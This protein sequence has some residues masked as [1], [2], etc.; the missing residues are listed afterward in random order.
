MIL[1]DRSGRIRMFNLAMEQLLGWTRYEVDGKLWTRTCTPSNHQDEA[2]HWISEA[3]RGALHGY[4]A[5]ALANTGAELSVRLEFA[6]VGRGPHQG[7]L[8]T[9]TEWRALE[10]NDPSTSA[11]LDYQIAAAPTSFALARLA[12]NSDPVPMLRE[13]A[14]CYTVIHGRQQPCEDCPVLR[15]ESEPWPREVVRT[16]Q[17]VDTVTAFQIVTAE[18]I[19][20]ALVRI[21]SHVVTPNVLTAIQSAKVERLAER[22]ELSARER[23]VLRYLLLGRSTEDMS[24]LIGI[25]ERTVK[26]HQ[27]N[28]LQK[29]GA[30]SR[31]DLMRLLF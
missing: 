29:L 18:R 30:E 10:R 13:D 28:V 5:H 17:S 26:Y 1:L 22:A 4:D 16:I 24:S 12:I 27:A 8:A 14:L 2:K 21:R 25:A 11:D 23:E 3:L 31:A 20:S 19:S 15:D 6:L 7:L 9:V